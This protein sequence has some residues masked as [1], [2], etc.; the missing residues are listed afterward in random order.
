M[1]KT[2]TVYSIIGQLHRYFPASSVRK[3]GRKS[4]FAS[5]A[6]SGNGKP[7]LTRRATSGPTR[8]ISSLFSFHA[9]V[10]WINDASFNS[11]KNVFPTQLSPNPLEPEVVRK[12]R[13]STPPR[14]RY[15]IIEILHF[16]LL[17]RRILLLLRRHL[18]SQPSFS[19]FCSTFLFASIP[20]SEILFRAVSQVRERK[21]KRER[22]RQRGFREEK[23][24]RRD[25]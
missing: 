23:A 4:S 18:R 3:S 9:A 8:N 6:S 16:E 19:I 11:F 25:F 20:D 15:P 7:H 17:L 2:Q 22:E 5:F 14:R 1:Q 24:R 13:E 10:I 12:Q 21:R